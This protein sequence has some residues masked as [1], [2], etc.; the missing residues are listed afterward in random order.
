MDQ[1][2]VGAERGQIVSHYRL[3][4]KIGEGGMGVFAH[5]NI[6]Q[7]HELGREGDLDFIV[8]EYIEGPRR[9]TLRDRADSPGRG[10][11]DGAETGGAETSCL[12]AALRRGGRLGRK[13]AALQ[14]GAGPARRC[15]PLP[16]AARGACRRADPDG[17][18]GAGSP[19]HVPD[20]KASAENDR[21][22][23][24]AAPQLVAPGRRRC[25]TTAAGPVC[26]STRPCRT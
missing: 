20:L 26:P 13:H 25:P 6:V 19:Q 4:E 11:L 22:F 18:G 8:M 14:A 21:G 15:A 17:V 5:G 1:R 12:H 3:V 10:G 9:A 2:T 7:V 23:P 16:R 24:P